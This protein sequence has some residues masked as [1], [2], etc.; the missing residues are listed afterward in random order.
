MKLLYPDPRRCR[1]C[2]ELPGSAGAGPWQAERERVREREREVGRERERTVHLWCLFLESHQFH[3][4]DPSLMTSSKPNF[5]PKAWP[6]HLITLGIITSTYKSGRT[7]SSPPARCNI[8]SGNK[9]SIAFAIIISQ[10][11][12]QFIFLLGSVPDS[13]TGRGCTTFPFFIRGVRRE[14]SLFKNTTFA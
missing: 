4:E 3:H 10:F 5:C 6:L 11:Y 7:Q 9:K 13:L 12:E 8:H 1:P 14:H 2:F